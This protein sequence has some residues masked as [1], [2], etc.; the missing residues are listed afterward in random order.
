MLAEKKDNPIDYSAGIVLNYKIG[1]F[2][3]KGDV[4]ATFYTS[5][6]SKIDNSKSIFLSSYEFSDTLPIKKTL[7]Y[8]VVK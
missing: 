1:S 5:S 7:I 2:V 8:E 3:K 4:L 6:Q